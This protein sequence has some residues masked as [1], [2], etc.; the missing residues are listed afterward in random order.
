[1][2][3]AVD[4]MGGDF[5]PEQIVFG[6]VRAAKKYG[7]EIV[8]VGDEEKIREVL[9]RETGWEKLGITIHHTSQVI[10]MD[11]HP[12]DAVRTKK[13]SSVVVATKLVKDGQCDAVLS[14]GSTGAAVTAAQLI[15]KRIKGIGRPTIA[16]PIPTT[17]GVTLMLDSGANVD[18]KP[19]HLVQSGMMGS[20]Y[21]EYE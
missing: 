21:A 19:I 2:K 13:D 4:A 6:A 3:I 15:L 12:A 17:K 8:L 1:M 20:I 10:E 7:C 14:A 18:S 11:E 16:T 9:K 5:A